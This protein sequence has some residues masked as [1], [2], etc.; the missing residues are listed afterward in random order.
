MMA[1]RG[2]VVLMVDNRGSL[3]FGKRG[4]A[5]L[6]RRFG[7]VNLAAQ[8]AGVAYLRRLDLVDPGRIGLWG[9]SGGGA[10]TL[11][12]LTH[13]PGTWRAGVAGAPVTDWLLYDSIWTERYLDHPKDNPQGYR[14]SSALTAAAE[15]R[16]ALL[17]VHGTADDN[18]HPQNTMVMSRALVDAGRP[19]EQA[20]YAG[21]KHGFQGAD[22]RHFYERMTEFFD[23]HLAP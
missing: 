10:N 6:H 15:L 18:V 12:A 16:D 3:F 14:D 9:W 21:Q 13:S 22:L 8:R 17:I 23:R 4:A 2:Y 1:A 5:R 19:F 20:I 11:Y 7:E